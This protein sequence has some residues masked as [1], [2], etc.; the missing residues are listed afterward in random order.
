MVRSCT[1]VYTVEREPLPENDPLKTL[2]NVIVNPHCGSY[3]VGSKKT[4]IQ[5]VCDLV[6]TAVTTGK[7]TARCVADR[8]V[9]NKE[10][11]FTFV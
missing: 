11:G 3:G 5:M 2:D 1:P 7:V 10:T 6:P 4:Q 9:L 8:D